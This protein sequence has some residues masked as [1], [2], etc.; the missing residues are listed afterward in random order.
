M[1]AA[2]CAD[3]LGF[4]KKQL[5]VT[6]DRTARLAAVHQFQLSSVTGHFPDR[7]TRSK[8]VIHFLDAQP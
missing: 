3:I 1:S 2:T 4:V 6:E 8:L 5:E 7:L